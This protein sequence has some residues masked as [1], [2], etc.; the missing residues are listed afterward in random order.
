SQ[1]LTAQ[2]AGTDI[3]AFANAGVDTVLSVKTARDFG[4]LTSGKQKLAAFLLTVRD[5]KSLGLDIAQNTILTE[6]FYWDLDDRTRAF[7][8]RFESK[9]GAMPS[10]I[11][12]GIYSSVR[13]YLKAVVAAKTD[14][15]KT[16]IKKMR[17]LPIDD[18]VIRNGR[19][20]E[21]GRMV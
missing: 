2:A 15:A 19:L 13:H 11:H 4:L 10:M 1:M 20:R 17:E 18:D 8:K 12:A 16:V 5:V 3:I 6:G 9:A 21:D 7:S 14:E